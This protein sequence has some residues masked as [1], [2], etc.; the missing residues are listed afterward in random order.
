MPQT[1]QKLRGLINN[2]A[3]TSTCKCTLFSSFLLLKT[4]SK[5]HDRKQKLGKTV[6]LSKMLPP[7]FLFSMSHR[8]GR[9]AIWDRGS[10]LF[11][12]QLDGVGMFWCVPSRF[13]TNT[14]QYVPRP[15][16]E[17]K[18]ASARLQ[19]A[20]KSIEAA[21]NQDPVSCY[22]H[23]SKHQ[24]LALSA[25]T[26]VCF[27][28]NWAAEERT[29]MWLEIAYS[30]VKNSICSR[31]AYCWCSWQGLHGAAVSQSPGSTLAH[32]ARAVKVANIWA[33]LPNQ[34]RFSKLQLRS[35]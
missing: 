34:K 20:S 21:T 29:P 19:A 16:V 22:F 18:G 25:E 15:W 23:V 24:R 7:C 32:E 26:C 11:Q 10:R 2:I 5:I 9:G 14:Q 8:K 17:L 31:E 35:T 1:P 30:E 12:H 3:I 28:F 4:Q 13:Y 33:W 27:C 6:T